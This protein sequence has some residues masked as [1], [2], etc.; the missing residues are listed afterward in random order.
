MVAR[1]SHWIDG[2]PW[3]GVAERTGEVYD[4][5][6]GAVTG[7]V[8][9]ASPT[10]VDEAV[11]AAARA[12]PALAGHLAGA[13]GRKV[14]FAFRELL[15]EHQRRA[16]RDRH[17]RARQGARRRGGRGRAG[18]RERRVRL[19]D[20]GAAQGRVQRER[21]HPGRRVLDAAA[22]RRGRR[23]LAVQLPGDGAAV[24][25]AQRDRVR[26][27]GGAEAVGEG[28]VGGQL[29]RRPVGA[30]RPARRRAQRAAR[31]Q[32]GGRR[33]ADPSGGARDLV[34][35]LHA[36]RP[37]RLRDRHRATASGCRRSAARRTTWS[38][39]RTPTSTWPPTPRSP[40]ASARRASA[41][42]PSR[43]WSPSTRSATSWS[44]A[45]GPAWPSCASATAAGPAARWARWSPPRTATR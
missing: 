16:G 10:E 20:A 28:P 45:S 31:R 9:F 29:H 39:C 34:R 35:R 4:P 17:R 14:L 36:D 43:S 21:V 19:R 44:T 30:G 11:A 32:G 13:R 1:I 22:A 2:K 18:D 27:H 33:A 5:A 3:A 41:A 40:P 24:V 26:Q 15:N 42:W 6:T 38:C 37:L 7:Q 25:R 12:F 23:D 8:D